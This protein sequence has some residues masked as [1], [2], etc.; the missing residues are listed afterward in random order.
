[1]NNAI[2]GV[3]QAL[4]NW[5]EGSTSHVRIMRRCARATALD[6]DRSKRTAPDANPVAPQAPD[7]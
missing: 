4:R 5:V 2:F 6:V 7:A 1:M 3:C